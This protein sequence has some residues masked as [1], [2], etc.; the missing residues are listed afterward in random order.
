MNK[1]QKN[2]PNI[3]IM[4]GAP[5]SGKTTYALDLVKTDPSYVRV[6]RD[7]IRKMVSGEYVIADKLER[8]L[9]SEVQHATILSALKAG[10]NVV[11]D[12]TNAKMAYIKEI[13]SKYHELATFDVKYLHTDIEE[14]LE[15][16]RTREKPV[17]VD[18]IYRMYNSVKTSVAENITEIVAFENALKDVKPVE[19]PANNPELE[20]CFLFDIDGTLAKMTTRRPFEWHKVGEDEPVYN[21]ITILNTISHFGFKII[22]MSGR[23]EVCRKQTE[24]WLAEHTGE[25]RIELYMRP[26]ND[27]RKDNIVKRELYDKH[28]KDKYNVV[29][30]FDDRDQVVDMWRKELGL[31]CLQVDYGNF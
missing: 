4:A 14:L 20:N 12:N 25:E 13:V 7:D 10:K 30:I 18:V 3:R 24:I 31:T 16:N 15:R 1:L 6:N 26:Q 9:V 2:K 11:I 28:I 21:I 22:Y 8:T 29:A 23:D 19:A 5:G 27:Y 17:P